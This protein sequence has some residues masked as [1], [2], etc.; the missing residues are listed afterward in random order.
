MSYADYLRLEGTCALVL[1]AALVGV[2]AP[3]LEAPVA[4]VISG[5]LLA[6]ILAVAGR[7]SGAPLAQPGAWFTTRP[8]AGASAE[9]PGIDR[10]RL[11]RRL[12]AETALWAGAV[13]AWVLL[14]GESHDIVFA[15]GLASAA[16]GAIQAF[17]A[18][19]R[20]V[21]HA[22]GCASGARPPRGSP[23]AGSR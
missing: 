1:G 17:A 18:R 15:T 20:V 12:L 8:L 4:S 19:G 2:G 23:R 9:R 10:T 21:N 6:A 16:F 11:T 13:C 22:P 3:G 5:I 7:R 14:A